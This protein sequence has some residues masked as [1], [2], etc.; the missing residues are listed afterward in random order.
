MGELAE[1]IGTSQRMLEHHFHRLFAVTPQAWYRCINL[2]A[3]R[4]DRLQGTR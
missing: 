2:N 1:A 3:A 4:R